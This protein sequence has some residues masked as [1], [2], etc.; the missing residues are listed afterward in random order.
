[1]CLNKQVK[2]YSLIL[3]LADSRISISKSQGQAY[4]NQIR[5]SVSGSFAIKHLKKKKNVRVAWFMLGNRN[6]QWEEGTQESGA[7]SKCLVTVRNVKMR[8]WRDGSD[9]SRMCL[10]V[11]TVDHVIQVASHENENVFLHKG[12]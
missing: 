3:G 1:M 5:L 11:Y 6:K 12:S 9:V 10:L 7:Q 4:R 8:G 2:F